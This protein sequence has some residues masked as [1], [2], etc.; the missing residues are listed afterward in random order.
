MQLQLAVWVA[1]AAGVATPAVAQTRESPVNITAFCGVA[2]APG[3][4]PAIG[5][6]VGHK[7][8]PGPVSLEF[9]YW[10]SW[11]DPIEGVPAIGTFAVNILTELSPRQSRFQFYGTFGAGLYALL[12][13]DQVSEVTD[14]RNIGGGAKVSLAGPLKLRMDYRAFF[15]TKLD[16]KDLSNEHRFYVGIVA[17]F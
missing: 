14:A 15:L 3:P 12:H 2:M 1:L 4:H 10:R 17:G 8:H 7:P 13:E 9:E 11:R 6:A 5:V 16:G